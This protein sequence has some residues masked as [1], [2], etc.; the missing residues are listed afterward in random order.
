MEKKSIVKEFILF[1]CVLYMCLIHLHTRHLCLNN[2]NLQKNKTHTITIIKL[3][4]MKFV[5]IFI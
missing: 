2:T 1:I 5:I 3:W 4:P